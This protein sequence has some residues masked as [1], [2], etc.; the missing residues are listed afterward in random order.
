MSDRSRAQEPAR[1]GRVPPW[2]DV[3][4]SAYQSEKDE[5]IAA[6]TAGVTV[7]TVRNWAARDR[8][9][10][11]KRIAIREGE[12]I[13]QPPRAGA[14]DWMPPFLA[15]LRGSGTV[16]YACEAAGVSR[17]TVYAW[18]RRDP[19]FARQWDEAQEDAVEAL[20]AA[21]RVRALSGSD[22]LL[23]F[24]LR[25][26]RPDK[27]GDRLRIEHSIEREKRR[28]YREALAEGLTDDEAADAVAEFER[29]VADAQTGTGEAERE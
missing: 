8:E 9:F 22:R 3:F 23:M 21:A 1:P 20:E 29:M 28:V 6:R 12:Q 18:K 13:V 26:I 16:R 2:G 17:Q 14:G 10:G 24:L 4:L 27:Y 5:A 11:A 25:A 15:R 7:K 19:E